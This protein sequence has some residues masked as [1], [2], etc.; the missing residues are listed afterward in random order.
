MDFFFL[1]YFT[2]LTLL[3]KSLNPALLNHKSKYIYY[4]IKK[5][6]KSEPHTIYN[7]SNK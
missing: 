1:L 7:Y 4:T 5:R 2:L 6:K 3:F